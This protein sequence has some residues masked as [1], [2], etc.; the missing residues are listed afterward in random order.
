MGEPVDASV[1]EC[2]NAHLLALQFPEQQVPAVANGD[3]SEG[4]HLL[5]VANTAYIAEA[6]D[7]SADASE[8]LVSAL[9]V[10]KELLRQSLAI[11]SRC[12]SHSCFGAALDQEAVRYSIHAVIL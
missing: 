12:V 6:V 1:L 4:F 9:R 7:N 2:E 5:R 3:P 10:G 8:I 11:P